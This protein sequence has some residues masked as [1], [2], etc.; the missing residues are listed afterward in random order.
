MYIGRLERRKGVKYLLEA[1]QLF[2][3]HNPD[4]KLIIA[5]DG[6]ERER[7]ELLTDDLKLTRNV[8]F[9][10]YVSEETKLGLLGRA[11]LFCS[12][13]VFGESF[14][15]VLLEAMAAGAV[16]LAGN[17]SGYIDV[18]KGMGAV[19]IVT[20]FNTGKLA[21]N[22]ARSFSVRLSIVTSHVPPDMPA[23]DWSING[24]TG[25]ARNSLPTRSRSFTS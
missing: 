10:G 9:L 7:L 18:M 22:K 11:D 16:C 19:S 8:E 14:G 25:P 5:G 2:A 4:T 1:F 24:T 21:R 6:P 12:P 15:I 13:A 3:Q 20:L 23:T 17:N